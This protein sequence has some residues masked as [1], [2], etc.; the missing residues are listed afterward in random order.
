MCQAQP[1][2]VGSQGDILRHPSRDADVRLFGDMLVEIRNL[3]DQ[4]R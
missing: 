2:A 3:T 4:L 1:N